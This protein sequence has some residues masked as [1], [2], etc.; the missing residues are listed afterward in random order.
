[1]GC[2]CVLV[3]SGCVTDPLPLIAMKSIRTPILLLHGRDDKICK[4]EK[5]EPIA[6]ALPLAMLESYADTAHNFMLE[7]SDFTSHKV[8]EFVTASDEELIARIAAYRENAA[9]AT[10]AAKPTASDATTNSKPKS[11]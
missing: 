1:M 5:V 7:R 10:A 6:S 11:A 8:A 4:L 3:V 2:L 9:A